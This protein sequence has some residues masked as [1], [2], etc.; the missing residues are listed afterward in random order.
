[1]PRDYRF[2]LYQDNGGGRVWRG[3]FADLEEAKRHAQ[4]FADE[5]HHE[6]FVCRFE[7][8]SEVARSFPSRKKPVA[9]PG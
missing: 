5:E 2:G 8:Y 1:M 3:S 7:D 4:K 6:F 9:H